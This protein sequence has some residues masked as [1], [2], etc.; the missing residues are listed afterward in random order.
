MTRA[1]ETLTLL[2][3]G[4]AAIW[5]ALVP[6][7]AS[8]RAWPGPDLVLA[9][10][11]AWTLRRPPGPPLWAALL[12]GLAADLLLWRPPGLGA[13]ALVAA[14]EL[15]RPRAAALRARGFLACWAAAAVVATLALF[16]M[17]AV[18]ALAFLDAAPAGLIA[19]AALA[20]ALA[21]P[22]AAGLVALAPG[23]RREPAA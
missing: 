13:L 17:N 4:I 20:T 12:L 1:L 14:V 3:A 9:L 23:R 15:L 8:A 18:L 16:A 10:A 22:L 19:R 11:L 21:W 7:D 2:G 6:Y 5:L